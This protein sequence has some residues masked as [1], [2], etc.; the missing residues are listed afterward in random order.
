MRARNTIIWT[1][2][3]VPVLA[4]L[5]F[6]IVAATPAG[7]APGPAQP[8]L[9]MAPLADFSLDKPGDGRVLLRFSATIVNVGQGPMELNA[10]R[11]TSSGPFD[12]A[13]SIYG[14]E[15]T[16]SVSTPGVSLVYGGD[17]HDHW[18]V[19]NL[20]SYEL[21]RLDNGVKVGTA[22][23]AGFCFFDTNAYRTSLP[24][25]PASAVYRPSNACAY[26]TPSA[27]SVTMGI[28]VGWGDRYAA[29]LP[30][31]YI[32]ITGLSAGKYRLEATAD[33]HGWFAESDEANNQTWVDLSVTVHR[34][35]GTS[36]KIVRFGPS[37]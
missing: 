6:M 18:H 29:S 7:S 19:N 8:D 4:A 9:G 23:K 37:A 5:A 36:V 26:N 17:G 12:V 31:Q 27:T 10:T 28:S 15:E 13:Q 2:F 16:V 22:A 11:S 30:D 35:H 3:I 33:P 14:S 24:G 21:K 1:G 32:D 25:A 20:E 34:K